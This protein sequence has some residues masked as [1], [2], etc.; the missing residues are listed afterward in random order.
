MT[1][2]VQF[3]FPDWAEK[4]RGREAELNLFLAAQ[5]QTNRGMLF[6]QEGA[7]N[8]HARWAPLRMRDGQILS[9]RGTLRKSIAPFNPNGVRGENGIVRFAGDTIVVGTKLAYARMMNNGTVGLPGGVLRPKHAKALKIPLPPGFVKK[10][11]RKVGAL[12][13]A[14]QRAKNAES[15]AHLQNRLQRAEKALAKLRGNKSKAK[16]ER[17]LSKVRQQMVYAIATQNHEL[18]EKMRKRTVRTMGSQG[19]FMF[20]KSVTIPPRPFDEWNE[21]DQ[22]EIDSALTT[23]VAEVL[24]E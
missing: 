4:L 16:R 8:G 21:A 11:A 3:S 10:R 12:V 24:G 22:A 2:E 5:I 7:H 14:L 9:R 23:K 19:D 1:V 15:V 13:S 20:V 18:A 17:Y 6:D